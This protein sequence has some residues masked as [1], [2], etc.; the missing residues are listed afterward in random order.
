MEYV[1]S[2]LTQQK[3]T[4]NELTK[5]L[6]DFMAEANKKLSAIDDALIRQMLDEINKLK[7]DLGQFKDDTTEKINN[8][9]EQ[10]S[11]KAD[12]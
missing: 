7:S 10:L 1:E 9:L 6:D 3:K 8:I 4:I 12:K 11:R 5:K 2:A